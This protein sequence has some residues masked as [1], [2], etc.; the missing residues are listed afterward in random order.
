MGVKIRVADYPAW[1]QSFDASAEMRKTA[2]EKSYQLF[3][4]ADD[5]NELF[6]ICEWDSVE[7]ARRYVASDELREAQETS[8]VVELPDVFVLEELDSGTL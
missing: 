7:N 5:P 4:T 8:G 2:G 6:L 3:R 1:K